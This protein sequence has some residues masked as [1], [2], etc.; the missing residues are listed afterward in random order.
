MGIQARRFLQDLSSCS[1]WTSYTQHSKPRSSVCEQ[2]I[3]TSNA[4]T[5]PSR[6]R[7]GDY[8]LCSKYT[9]LFQLEIAVVFGATDASICYSYALLTARLE[10][11]CLSAVLTVQHFSKYAKSVKHISETVQGNY[12]SV[13]QP[14]SLVGMK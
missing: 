6:H 3:Y 14:W 8:F 12:I 13:K 9:L 2:S 11:Y 10:L 5:D 1:P 4:N 7:K